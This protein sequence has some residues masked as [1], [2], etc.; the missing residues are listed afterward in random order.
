MDF[1]QEMQAV[2]QDER[3]EKREIQRLKLAVNALNGEL[4][5]LTEVE[6]LVARADE[7]PIYVPQWVRD[8]GKRDGYSAMAM[9]QFSDSHFEEVVDPA[10]VKGYNA[11]NREIAEIRL[12]RLADKTIEQAQDFITGV[13]YA[14][15]TILSTGDVFS[16]DIH[17]ELKITNEDTLF[18]GVD[19]WVDPMSGMLGEFADY[20]GKVYVHAVVGNHG[21]MTRKPLYKNR[22]SSNIEW[23]FWR[24]MK[25]NLR[26]DD[27][28]T[29]DVSPALTATVDV[30]GTTYQIEHGDEF[31]GGDGQVGALGPLKRGQL[32]AARQNMA[33]GHDMDYL[34]AGH[35]HQYMPPSQG[36]IMGG[37]LKG[38][39]EFASGLHL[40]PEVPQQ[41]FWVSTPERGPTIF[42]P[43]QPMKRSLEGW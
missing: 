14:G 18:A 38:Y 21:R 15:I 29:I 39:D 25:R 22:A 24:M 27:R 36:L 7:R 11:Y 33:M 10:Q 26:G 19:Y 1:D 30:F 28:I 20:F 13:D 17:E 43:I 6:G 40:T 23:L 31:R 5:R 34:V 9:L 4:E 16:G 37:S 41:G 42:A 3:A 12:R 8:P 35:F 32:K 2:E